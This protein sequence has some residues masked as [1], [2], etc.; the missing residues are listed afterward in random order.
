MIKELFPDTNPLHLRIVTSQEIS[1][2]E[3]ELISIK[4]NI[5]A[6]YEAHSDKFK[7]MYCFSCKKSICS[8]CFNQ[9]HKEHI[10]K[11]K[12]DFL[13]PAHLLMNLIIA[14]STLYNADSRLSKYKES[15]S[16]RADLKFNVFDNL[17]KLIND[18]E[19]KFTSSLELFSTIEDETDKNANENLELLKKYC[20]E[21]FIKLK[22]VINTKGIVVEDEI[23]LTLYNKLEEI[24]KYKNEY[25]KENKQKFEKLNSILI[26]FTKQIQNITNSLRNNLEFY[27]KQDIYDNFK[28]STQKYLVEKIQKETVSDLM[29]RNIDLERKSLTSNK[30]DMSTSINE[31]KKIFLSQNNANKNWFQSDLYFTQPNGLSYESFYEYD[32]VCKDNEIKNQFNTYCYSKNMFHY[33]KAHG[34]SSNTE[35]E[36]ASNNLNI[37]NKEEDNGENVDIIKEE[38]KN[39]NSD[40]NSPAHEKNNILNNNSKQ[41]NLNNNINQ[42]SDSIYNSNINGLNKNTSIEATEKIEKMK[43]PDRPTKNFIQKELKYFLENDEN[44]QVIKEDTRQNKNKIKIIKNN[45]DTDISNERKGQINSNID[46]KE[47]NNIDKISPKNEVTQYGTPKKKNEQLCQ[48]PKSG[49]LPNNMFGGKLVVVL[50]N[51]INKTELEYQ[52]NFI[53]EKY[54]KEKEYSPIFDNNKF[55]PMFL[56]M[57]PISNNNIIIGA[58]PGEATGKVEVEF[59]KAFDKNDI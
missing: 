34:F 6:P 51:K 55:N 26:P 59:K 18:L 7:M 56:F 35:I 1:E 22:N 3:N 28:N 45:N 15:I 20:I 49:E 32:Y 52:K 50:N 24:E 33:I 40:V 48:T 12:A 19:L 58:L 30:I 11:E 38:L 23:F 14:D 21:F 42:I 41:N 4:L 27:L 17:R 46:I 16:Y 8:N 36:S 25:F 29:L 5:N 31:A 43:Y 44:K 2:F 54:E 53:N 13:A 37:I 9:E 57:H 10:V 39:L 47:T